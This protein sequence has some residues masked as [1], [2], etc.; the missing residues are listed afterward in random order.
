MGENILQNTG[1]VVESKREDLLRLL[2]PH[3]ASVDFGNDI[4]LAQDPRKL[5]FIEPAKQ[6]PW[7]LSDLDQ[8]AASQARVLQI[9][10]GDKRSKPIRKH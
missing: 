7:G 9:Q 1:R 4:S 10:L 3:V 6:Q 8:H 2:P 5:A